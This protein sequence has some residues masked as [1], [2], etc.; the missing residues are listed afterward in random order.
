MPNFPFPEGTFHPGFSL[1]TTKVVSSGPLKVV[2]EANSNDNAWQWRAAFY[3]RDDGG[4]RHQVGPAVLAAVRGD[5]G[6]Q[7]RRRRHR[8][9]GPATPRRW[10][11]TTATTSPTRSGPPS[12]TERRSGRCSSL[13]T[14]TTPYRPQH[15]PG[16]GL[17]RRRDDRVRV[18]SGPGWRGAHDR[19]A[20]LHRRAHRQHR[21]RNGGQRPPAAPTRTC[22][23]G[24]GPV[25]KRTGGGPGPRVDH[26]V[27]HPT[28]ASGASLGYLP[29]GPLRVADTRSDGGQRLP[30]AAGETRTFAVA[31]ANAIAAD[32]KAVAL[33]CR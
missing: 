18:R 16:A 2:L 14:R 5:A 1:A 28:A 11:P 10:A 26:N 15:R 19:H 13:T 24:T 23:I 32:A 7:G 8:V 17:R 20:D 31:G 9:P 30:L 27:D 25:E 21:R 22:S 12:A 29:V 33:P 4:R 3:P 6:R